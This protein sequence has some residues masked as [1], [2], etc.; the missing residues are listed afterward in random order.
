MATCLL[1][2]FLETSEDQ[3]A[4]GIYSIIFSSLK[5]VT[6]PLGSLKEQFKGLFEF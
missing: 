1:D 3:F 5:I 4:K 6:V 2:P